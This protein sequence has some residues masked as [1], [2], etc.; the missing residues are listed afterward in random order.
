V[1][2][3]VGF[4]F[5]YQSLFSLI[6]TLRVYSVLNVDNLQR[7]DSDIITSYV[8]HNILEDNIVIVNFQLQTNYLLI[9]F[10][11]PSSMYT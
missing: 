4:L 3:F 8:L 1:N 10:P 7:S 5:M 11:N 6:Y 9:S 2:A